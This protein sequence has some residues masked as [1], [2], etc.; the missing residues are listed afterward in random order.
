MTRPAECY[1]LSS[2]CLRH[3]IKY[4]LIDIYDYYYYYYYLFTLSMIYFRKDDM[5]DSGRLHLRIW[6][7]IFLYLY[8]WG[9]SLLYL[10][11]IQPFCIHQ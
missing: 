11:S 3:V 2:N 7:S 1:I 5:R 8:W 4:T 6:F 9:T 10:L